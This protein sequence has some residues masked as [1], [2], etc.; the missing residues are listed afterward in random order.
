MLIG[1]VQTFAILAMYFITAYRGP[2]AHMDIGEKAGR[3]VFLTFCIFIVLMIAQ[4]ISFTLAMFFSLGPA[5][6]AH[7][8][9]VP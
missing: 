4:F 1:F 6:K 9:A 3:S 2:Y 5:L 8:G 7:L